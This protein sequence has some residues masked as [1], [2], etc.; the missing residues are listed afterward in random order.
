MC[1]RIRVRG[2]LADTVK[3]YSY[4]VGLSAEVDPAECLVDDVTLR[5]IEEIDLSAADEL[6]AERLVGFLRRHLGR[7]QSQPLKA[8]FLALDLGLDSGPHAR[9]EARLAALVNEGRTAHNEIE[10]ATDLW[11]QLI[12]HLEGDTSGF[13]VTAY[14]D[15]VYLIILAR[16]LGAN[17][18]AGEA[19]L[20]AEDELS[21]ILDGSHF[22]D[23]YQLANMVEHDYF[24]WITEPRFL[25]ILTVVGK[26]MQTRL[27]RIR[28]RIGNRERPV[29]SAV[30]AACAA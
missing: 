11:S 27:V 10:L 29:R 18:L 19:L 13:R 1:R 2:V 23:R 3:W 15:A 25:P 4:D 28:L 21:A 8:R 20:S 12:D 30:G 22:R 7:E 5:C 24:G 14:A 17:V 16:L 9:S 6:A 26:E